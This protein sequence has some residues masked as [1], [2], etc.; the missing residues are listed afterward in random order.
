MSCI[1]GGGI[2]GTNAAKMALGLGARV[3]MIDLNLNRLRE[4]DDIFSGQRA[5]PRLQQLQHRKSRV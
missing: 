4:I 1:L 5:D 3:T 2:V